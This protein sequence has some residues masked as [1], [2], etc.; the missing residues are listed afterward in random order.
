MQVNHADIELRLPA[1]RHVLRDLLSQA[2]DTLNRDLLFDIDD[3]VDRPVHSLRDNIAELRP[4]LSFLDDP[5]NGLHVIQNHVLDQLLGAEYLRSR[6]FTGPRSTS[7]VTSADNI[8]C[9]RPEIDDYLYTNQVFLQLI[10]SLTILII[11]LPLRRKEF[12]GIS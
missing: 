1:W 2:S 9:N 12:V 11:R 10:V 4:G 5:R 8:T 7:G 6:F 3:L